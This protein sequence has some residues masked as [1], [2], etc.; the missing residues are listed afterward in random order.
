MKQIGSPTKYA[1]TMARGKIFITGI[2]TLLCMTLMTSCMFRGYKNDGKKVTFHSYDPKFII[3]Y[4]EDVDADPNTFEPMTE[5]YG[6]D[7]DHVFYWGKILDS[8]DASSFRI[9]DEFYT[10]DKNHIY[11]N[12]FIVENADTKT[13]KVIS[14]HLAEDKRDFYWNNTALNV[15]DKGSFTLIPDNEDADECYWAKD[16]YNAYNLPWCVS[17]PI[18]DFDSFRPLSVRY[19]VDKFQVYHRG[20]VV[21]NADPAT[22]KEVAWDIGQDKNGVYFKSKKTDASDFSK[23]EYNYEGAY[24]IGNGV[25]FTNDLKMIEGADIKSFKN[26]GRNSINENYWYLDKNTVW[27]GNQLVKGADAETFRLINNSTITMGKRYENTPLGDY[28]SDQNHVFYHDSTINGADPKTF[29]II[30][31]DNEGDYI[32]FDKYKIY[33]GKPNKGYLEYIQKKK[34]HNNY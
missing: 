1:E 21:I 23:L 33:S 5:L 9:I 18:K 11:F 22:F 34:Y 27:Y 12:T 8:V 3:P 31:F 7:K 10:A 14:K 17:V 30:M 16:K 32:A 2:I 19:A 24:Y 26:I 15:A 4:S 20:N 28:A 25:P 29:E 6:R 13:F